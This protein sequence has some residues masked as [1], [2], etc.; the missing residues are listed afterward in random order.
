[1]ESEGNAEYDAKLATSQFLQSSATDHVKLDELKFSFDAYCRE[2]N[3]TSSQ[4]LTREFLATYSMT[5]MPY[6]GAQ[7]VT[8]LKQIKV[9]DG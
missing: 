6:K 2:H 1:M 5:L 3:H 7:V 8:G 4:E 9:V